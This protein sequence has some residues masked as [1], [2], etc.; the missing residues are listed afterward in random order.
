MLAVDISGT[1]AD[2]IISITT[3]NS[4]TKC[5]RLLFYSV[6]FSLHSIYMISQPNCQN[7]VYKLTTT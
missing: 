6:I 4:K 7:G 5:K 3:V 1:R 2:K